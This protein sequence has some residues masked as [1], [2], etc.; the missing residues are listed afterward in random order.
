[1]TAIYAIIRDAMTGELSF[2]QEDI[3]ISDTVTDYQLSQGFDYAVSLSNA[4]CSSLP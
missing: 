4:Y 3:K 1:M 2:I